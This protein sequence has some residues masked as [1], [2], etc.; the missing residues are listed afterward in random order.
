MFEFEGKNPPV[1]RLVCRVVRKG[2]KGTLRQAP[3]VVFCLLQ[4]SADLAD[5]KK[6][7]IDSSPLGW[8]IVPDVNGKPG[9][10]EPGAFHS[11]VFDFMGGTDVD[12]RIRRSFR[13][14]DGTEHSIRK[15]LEQSGQNRRKELG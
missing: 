5:R 15:R 14:H 1:K 9:L 3:A 11:K 2:F 8:V 12:K 10:T 13:W 6:Q 4:T 7:G